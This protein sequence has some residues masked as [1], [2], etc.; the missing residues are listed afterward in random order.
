[1]MGQSVLKLIPLDRIDE[2]LVIIKK[3][4][5][6]QTL[7]HFET[8]RL[9]K[10]GKLIDISLTIS[11]IKDNQGRITG[12]SKIARDITDQFE[13]RKRI[14]E[15]EK[16]FHNLIYSSPTAIG[17]LNGED[18]VITIAN[19]M[20]IEILGKGKNIIGKKYFDVM[21]E[22]VE[23][24]YPEVYAQVYK[25][26]KPYSA[27]ETPLR[28]LQNG[29]YA[30]NYYNFILYPQYNMNNEIYGIGIIQSEVTAQA[31]ANKSIKE[32]EEWFRSLTQTLP[33]LVW[34]TDAQGNMDFASSRWKEYSGIEPKRIDDWKKILHPDDYNSISEK[35]W[36]SLATAKV[37]KSE[38]RLK[39]KEGSYKWHA[40]MA[41]PV[42]NSEKQIVKWVGALTDIHDQKEKEEKKDEFMTIASHEMKTPLTTAKAY[43]QILQL[44]LRDTQEEAKMYATKASESVDKL[45]E[46]IAD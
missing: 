12:A 18:L 42:L 34:V 22:L 29:E 14:E 2:E 13:T 16:R 46:L 17:I 11:P 30:L 25:T 37:F 19:E 40:A 41:E 4:Q 5:Q 3:I 7:D 32:R 43:L 23:L 38:M 36:H 44:T 10:D 21:P 6:G 27:T 15:S 31:L 28:I 35:W 24:G 26:G 33:Q 39:N 8:K 20:M 9:T 45:N 1:M